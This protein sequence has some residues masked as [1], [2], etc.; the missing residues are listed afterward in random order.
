MAYRTDF[1]HRFTPVM[2]VL[3]VVAMIL[4]F[5]YGG[6]VVLDKLGLLLLTIGQAALTGWAVIVIAAVYLLKFA[7]KFFPRGRS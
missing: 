4:D 6:E 2:L 5:H 1:L 3:G 7:A